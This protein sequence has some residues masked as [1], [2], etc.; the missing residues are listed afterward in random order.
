M[1]GV[2]GSFDVVACAIVAYSEWITIIEYERFIVD[3][4]CKES[5]QVIIQGSISKALLLGR[6][7]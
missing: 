6:I 5:N 7:E 2:G 1:W 4:R 3:D